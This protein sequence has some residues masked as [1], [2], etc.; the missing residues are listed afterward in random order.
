MIELEPATKTAVSPE[1]MTR[2]FTHLI[3]NPSDDRRAELYDQAETA[4][5]THIELL[6][7]QGQVTGK[8]R[9]ESVGYYLGSLPGFTILIDVETEQGDKSVQLRLEDKEPAFSITPLA[10]EV[11]TLEIE[12]KT[13]DYAALPI[14]E[15]FD[16]EDILHD[17]YEKDLIG[18]ESPLY[19]VVFR[20]TL[21]S[22]ADTD[23]LVQ[24][25]RQ[26]HEAALES[27]ALIYYFGGSP[28]EYGEALSFCL[29]QDI[30][31]AKAISKDKRHVDATKMVSAYERYSI[32]KYNVHHTAGEVRLEAIT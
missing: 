25:D 22:G 9:R 31:S 24:H 17:A 13:P 28:N 27:P 23:A 26:A 7:T 4:W 10:L 19:L 18:D 30:E 12:P 6:L 20:S 14:T 11:H 5:D 3:D 1:A 21:K 29:W 2:L 8:F 16:W 15:A 32:E